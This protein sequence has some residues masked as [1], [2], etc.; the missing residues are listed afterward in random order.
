ML[1][2][3]VL[4]CCCSALRAQVFKATVHRVPIHHCPSDA[5]SIIEHVYI[6]PCKLLPYKV[7]IAIL[8]TAAVILCTTDHLPVQST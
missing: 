5:V 6:V 4:I 8:Q 7:Y 1:H 2:I 3:L